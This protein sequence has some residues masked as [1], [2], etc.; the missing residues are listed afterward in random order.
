MIHTNAIILTFTLPRPSS[1]IKAGYL[2]CNV[3][4]Y[5]PDPLQCFQCQRFGYSRTSFRGSL[6]CACCGDEDHDA[7]ECELE[8]QCVN[9][10]GSHS[11]YFHS[12][13]KWVEEKEVQCL[14][15][16]N[17]ISYPEAWKYAA[18]LCSTASG[19]A[20]RSIHVSNRVIFKSLQDF[21]ALHD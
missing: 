21:F 1:T 16:V 13:P 8:P 18:A 2:N 19:S 14:K 17:N 12:C 20:N 15:T 3:R 9:C 6:M 7:Y 4:P 5:I 10:S 11:S